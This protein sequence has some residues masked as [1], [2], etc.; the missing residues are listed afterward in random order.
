M[1]RIF[2]LCIAVCTIV[3]CFAQTDTTG[4]QNPPND[5]I[6]IGGMII[7][8][9]AGSKPSPVDHDREYPDTITHVVKRANV[10]TNWAIVDIGFS[11]YSDKTIYSSPAAQAYAPGS[12]NSWFRLKYGKSVNINIWIFMQKLNVSKHILNLK[13]GLG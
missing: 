7:I 10:S 12:N 4:K 1:K 3:T 2:T 13:Y 8:R 6:R 9:K 11:N 5:T